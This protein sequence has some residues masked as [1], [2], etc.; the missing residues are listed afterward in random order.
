M[1]QIDRGLYAVEDAPHIPEPFTVSRCWEIESTS[2]RVK[3]GVPSYKPITELEQHAV[4]FIRCR[5]ADLRYMTDPKHMDHIRIIENDPNNFEEAAR[6]MDSDGA[7]LKPGQIPYNM[8]CD[9]DRRCLEVSVHRSMGSG[10][11][12]DA[13]DIY[14][15]YL[16]M[17]FGSC[18]KTKA[19]IDMLSEF[20]SNAS[21]LLMKHRDHFSHSVYVF[22]IGLAVYDTSSSYRKAFRDAYADALGLPAD[23]DT[24]DHRLAAK[25]LEFW[26]LTSLFHDIGY[27]Q[28]FQLLADRYS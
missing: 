11:T 20:E 22:L 10:I 18:H 2:K 14:F 1:Q 17:F 7:S 19:M 8:Q 12:K 13:F 3:K 21:S 24:E 26:G 16:E 25:F 28:R 27:A 6:K 15:C 9:L 23:T 4:S 5:C